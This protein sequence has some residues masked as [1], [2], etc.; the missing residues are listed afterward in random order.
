MLDTPEVDKSVKDRGN[1]IEGYS[2]DAVDLV[3]RFR[4]H[5][6]YTIGTLLT[7]VEAALGDGVQAQALKAI[8]RREMYM[9]IDRNQAEI[10]EHYKMQKPGLAPK[11][12]YLDG[13]DSLKDVDNG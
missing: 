4:D 13:Q 9:L 2:Y 8:V 7:A 12:I 1:K 6:N 11:E 3:T 5:G 10:Y